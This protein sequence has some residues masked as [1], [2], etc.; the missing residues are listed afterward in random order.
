MKPPLPIW[1]VP[2]LLVVVGIVLFIGNLSPTLAAVA[3]LE[4][5]AYSAY[6]IARARWKIDA[7]RPVAN[8]LPLFP[9]HL[10]LLLAIS[11]LPDPDSLAAL[12]TIVPI[13]SIAYDV[14]TVWRP[15]QTAGRASILATLYC[16]IWADLFYLLERVIAQKRAFSRNEEIIAAAAFGGGGILFLIVGIYRHRRAAK[17]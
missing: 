6:V 7:P 3:A 17:E 10:L 14:A 16:I 1:S 2:L 12:W 4:T 5:V 9:G 11:M 15:K 8:V 13:A